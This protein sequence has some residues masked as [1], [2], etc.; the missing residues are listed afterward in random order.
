MAGLDCYPDIVFL[1]H[2]QDFQTN[3]VVQRHMLSRDG[4]H[5]SFKGTET[6]VSRIETEIKRIMS[7]P[8]H[9]TMLPLTTT[10]SEEA[11]RKPDVSAMIHT[12]SIQLEDKRAPSTKASTANHTISKKRHT[13]SRVQPTPNNFQ[14]RLMFLRLTVHTPWSQNQRHNPPQQKT[15]IRNGEFSNHVLSR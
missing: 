14:R 12:S 5:L 4:I 15:D 7:K 9:T 8:K 13:S 3:G 1:S 2:D 11:P 10:I 6:I